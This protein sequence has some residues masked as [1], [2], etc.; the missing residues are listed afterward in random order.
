MQRA[1]ACSR[2]RTFA[3]IASFSLLPPFLSSFPILRFPSSPRSSIAP[4]F[5]PSP[6][7]PLLLLRLLCSPPSPFLF[8]LFFTSSRSSRSLPPCTHW[9]ASLHYRNGGVV[10]CILLPALVQLSCFYHLSRQSLIPAASTITIVYMACSTLQHPATAPLPPPFRLRLQWR[11]CFPCTPPMLATRPN[12][13]A[14]S[15]DLRPQQSPPPATVTW[16]PSLCPSHACS[17]VAPP[18]TPAALSSS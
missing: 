2:P 8:F 4:F 3:P 14:R 6:P 12:R 1:C 5:P 11:L 16:G 13:Q 9:R 7:P 10:C 17:S 15:A 18:K